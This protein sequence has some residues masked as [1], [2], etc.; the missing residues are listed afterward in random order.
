MR[1]KLADWMVASDNEYFGKVMAN[2]VWADMM[3]RGLVEPV[4]DLR[5][6]NPAT[7]EPLLEALGQ[8]FADNEYNIKNLLESLRSHMFIHSVQNQPI[9]I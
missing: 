5:A 2:R 6:T 7:N 1:G 3:G 8:Y 4:D 9:V